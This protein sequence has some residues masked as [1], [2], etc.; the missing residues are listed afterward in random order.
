MH[1]SLFGT[2]E[3]EGGSVLISTLPAISHLFDAGDLR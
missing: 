1:E 2:L 3:A